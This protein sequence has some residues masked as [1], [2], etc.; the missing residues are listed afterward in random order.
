MSQI[1]FQKAN[2]GIRTLSPYVPGKPISELEREYG[3]TGI[4]KLA[5]NENPLGPSPKAIAAIKKNLAE[6]YLYPD[7]NS[8]DLKAALAAKYAVA[9]EQITIGNGS[10]ELLD[11]IARI[12][13]CPGKN[14]VFAQ[15]SFAV[16]A[17][18]TQ[19]CGAK[20]VVTP[21]FPETSERAYQIDFDAMLAAVN[22]QTGVVFITNPNNP[23]GTWAADK[24]L[25][26]FLQSIPQ[27]VVVVMDE[28]YIEYVS[29]PDFPD[30]AKWLPEFPN[31]VVMRTFSKAYGLAGLRVGY[32]LSS[33]EIADYLNRARQPFNVNLLAQIAAL[34]A[35]DDSEH[36]RSSVASNSQGLAQLI[37]GFNTLGLKY[38]PS[39]ANFICVKVGTGS[40]NVYEKLL[41]QGIIVR[42]IAN[43]GLGEYLRITVGTQE[44][45]SRVITALAQAIK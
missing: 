24:E 40:A 5:S 11:L 42:P 22:E 35:L 16:Y 1:L 4:I 2:E 38:I 20:S 15:H 33:P 28:A 36:I 30:T 17:I 41:R 23:T 45:N 18:A 13:L 27:E 44:Q 37:A 6:S 21:V 7:G 19:M 29:E 39:V 32:S 9:A 34:A 31:L 3:V 25:Y 43:Y 10:N 14:S 8:F 12:F 26:R